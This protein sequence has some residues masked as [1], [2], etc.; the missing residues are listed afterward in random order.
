NGRLQWLPLGELLASAGSPSLRD[1]RTLA[2]LT[3]AARSDPFSERAPRVTL[4]TA[5]LPGGGQRRVRLSDFALRSPLSDLD[6]AGPDH[7]LN[8]D[9]SLIEFN[10]RVQDLAEDPSVP[11]LARIRFLSILSA[12]LDEFFMVRVGTLKRAAASGGPVEEELHAIAIR[13]RALLE[14]QARCFRDVCLPALAAHGVRILRWSDVSAAQQEV[15]RR[16]FTE[17]VFPL[18]TP[19]AMTRAPGHP[20]PL[21][22]NLRLSLAI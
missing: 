4:T 6:R 13:V 2:A 5:T 14:R 15:L 3:V 20:F 12:N 19:Q 17:E 22:P 8:G 11:L 7:F 21:I 16:S 9:L 1:P 18:I 10:A